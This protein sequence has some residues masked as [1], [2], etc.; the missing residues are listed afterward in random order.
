MTCLLRNRANIVPAAFL[1]HLWLTFPADSVTTS[2]VRTNA[3]AIRA[4]YLPTS[5]LATTCLSSTL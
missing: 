4:Y 2:V 1:P 5:H 3:A